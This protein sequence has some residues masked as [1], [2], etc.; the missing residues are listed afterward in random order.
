MAKTKVHDPDRGAQPDPGATRRP[1]SSRRAPRRRPP[2]ARAST[3]PAHGSGNASTSRPR[4]RS[5]SSSPRS[6]P[7]RR[8]A[9]AAGS[10]GPAGPRT[11]SGCTP[12]P[13]GCPSGSGS[14]STPAPRTRR[15][16]A[17]PVPRTGRHR[18]R[19][20]A[21]AGDPAPDRLAPERGPAGDAAAA[22]LPLGPAADPAGAG[23]AR[24]LHGPA[25]RAAADG[26]GRVG[27]A[28]H[29]ARPHRR[30]RGAQGGHRPRAG[31]VCRRRAD[32]PRHRDRARPGRG[33]A[34]VRHG[35]GLGR[36]PGGHRGLRRPP[37]PRTAPAAVP[38]RRGGRE[39][40]HGR[41]PVARRAG[42]RDP[43]RPGD[44]RAAG[45]P[46]AGRPADRGDADA[47]DEPVVG[48]VPDPPAAGRGD[49]AAPR[50]RWRR[51]VPGPRDGAC[52]PYAWTWRAATTRMRSR[53]WSR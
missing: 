50:G 11:P 47:L 31:L 38:G 46:A 29:R 6:G 42:G 12:T 9:S 45:Q 1:R 4:A 22:A 3:F 2:A 33:R 30:A 8:W 37:A 51:R 25:R 21:A 19:P 28:D 24:P 48:A 36:R 13:P 35:D 32:R 20:R 41:P 43:R 27:H 52:A 23:A 44:H 26:P 5:P 39:H 40:R 7:G 15:S 18:R 17:A 16:A 14:C 34:P 53:D 10:A 49:P